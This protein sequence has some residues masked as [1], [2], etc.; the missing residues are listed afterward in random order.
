MA[1]ESPCLAK[2]VFDPEH[3]VDAFQLELAFGVVVL[4]LALLAKARRIAAS[5]D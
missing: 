4:A 1:A 5:A 2:G 3:G